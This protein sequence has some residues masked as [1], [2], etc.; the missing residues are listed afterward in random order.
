[1]TARG[2]HAHIQVRLLSSLR[3]SCRCAETGL[4]LCSQACPLPDAISGAVEEAFR[5]EGERE[6]MHFEPD[7]EAAAATLRE[8]GTGDYV[9]V[10]LPDGRTMLAVLKSGQRFNLQFGR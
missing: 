1:M 4:L 3:T 8:S 7:P 10:E 9:R 5:V 6:G 2:G